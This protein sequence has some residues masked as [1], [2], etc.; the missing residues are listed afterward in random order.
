[1]FEKAE[2]DDKFKDKLIE[3]KNRF[4]I[5]NLSK[6]KLIEILNSCDYEEFISG[7]RY[8]F[9]QMYFRNVF[10]IYDIDRNNGHKKIELELSEL[11]KY[12]YMKNHHLKFLFD[13]K[14]GS[15]NNTDA[16]Y[17]I[18]Y[19]YKKEYED[20]SNLLFGYVSYSSD[21]IEPIYYWMFE[22]LIESI[23]EI[24]NRQNR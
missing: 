24:E 17:F 20:I 19:V 7:M 16:F 1:M 11:T 12:H 4:F 9:Y 2:L 5:N 10:K 18:Q 6:E 23:V 14:I 3:E 15:P 21:I 13:D 8:K 22:K